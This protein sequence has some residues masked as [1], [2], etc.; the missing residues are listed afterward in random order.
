MSEPTDASAERVP[1]PRTTPPIPGRPRGGPGTLPEAESGSVSRTTVREPQLRFVDATGSREAADRGAQVTGDLIDEGQDLIASSASFLAG[2]IVLA[3]VHRVL[4]PLL[5]AACLPQA[6]AGEELSGGQWQRIALARA[7]FRPAGLL[8]LDE[9]TANLDPRAEY[10]IF[11]RLR[12]L[13]R[14]R[15]VLLVTHR[16]TN[17]AVADRIVVLDKGRIVQQGTYAEL[18]QQ[19]G[20]FQQ[21]LS[22]QVT[23]EADGEQH[24]ARP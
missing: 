16:I 4:L 2:A 17:V 3:G 5:V 8:V 22:Y 18:A 21:L 12:D 9:P 7:F 11:Q 13:A 24:G 1:G 20:M 6:L 15:A 23:S 14:D 19:P 10:R